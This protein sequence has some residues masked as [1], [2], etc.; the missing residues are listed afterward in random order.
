VAR[1]AVNAE[2][3]RRL[4]DYHVQQ[5]QRLWT[6]TIVPMTDAQFTQPVDYSVGSVRNQV[7]HLLNVDER[8]FCGLRGVE[9]PGFLNPAHFPTREKVRMKWDQVERDMRFWLARLTDAE[10]RLPFETTPMRVWE[11]L[12]HV[13]NHGTDHRAQ[14]LALAAQ[15][16]LPTFAQ[17]YAYVALGIDA[18]ALR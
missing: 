15:L 13:L 5:N 9:P 18:A 11:V 14:T 2:G 1:A 8:W 4:F 7:V 12:F 16:G 6:H 3:F 10:L 17:D